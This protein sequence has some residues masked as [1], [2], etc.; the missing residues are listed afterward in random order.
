MISSE[1]SYWKHSRHR[2]AVLIGGISQLA[3]LW[4]NIQEYRNLSR[5]REAIFSEAEWERIAAG[6]L[7]R[8]SISALAAV[9]FLLFL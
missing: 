8:C 5:V 6:A 7:R 9:I 2:W 4:L 1:F 3:A